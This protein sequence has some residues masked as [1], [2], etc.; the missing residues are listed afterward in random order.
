LTTDQP[1]PHH[2]GR[3]DKRRST[4][5]DQYMNPGFSHLVNLEYL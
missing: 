3:I 5:H 2:D 1:A 4:T